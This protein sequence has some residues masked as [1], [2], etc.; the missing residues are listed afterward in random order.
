MGRQLKVVETDIEELQ[1]IAINSYN[2]AQ[3]FLSAV[4]ILKDS[5]VTSVNFRQS[6]AAHFK[7]AARDVIK[8]AMGDDTNI[9]NK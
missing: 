4:E 6:G 3:M 2:T 1:Q 5:G 8:S 7:T 9:T